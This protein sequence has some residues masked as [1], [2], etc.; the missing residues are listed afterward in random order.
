LI[1]IVRPFSEFLPWIEGFLIRELT[2]LI[3][4]E[5]TIVD[6]KVENNK[7]KEYLSGYSKHNRRIKRIEAEL[8]EIRM[9]KTLP[10]SSSRNDG[11]PHGSSHA[12]LSDYI[13]Q[14]DELDEELYQEGVERVKEYKDILCRINALEDED[15]RDILFYRYIKGLD[16]WEVA[17]KIN[18]SERQVYRKHGKAL[19]NLKITTNGSSCQSDI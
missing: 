11:M 4:W 5:V 9:I 12:D 16:W 14:L 15:E 1:W 13:A 19:E 3:L 10:L 6:T 7:K 2:F 18:R 8:E 17:Q